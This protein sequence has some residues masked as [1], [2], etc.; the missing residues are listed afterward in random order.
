MKIIKIRIMP[1]IVFLSI[2]SGELSFMSTGG[3]SQIV[4]ICQ[5]NKILKSYKPNNN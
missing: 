2:P 1:V 4:Q 3:T 5:K